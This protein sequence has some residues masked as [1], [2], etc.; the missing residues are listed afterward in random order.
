VTDSGA[1]H[2]TAARNELTETEGNTFLTSPKIISSQ[3]VGPPPGRCQ[4]L[5]AVGANKSR[6]KE[7][8]ETGEGGIEAVKMGEG[9]EGGAVKTGID[10]GDRQYQDRTISKVELITITEDRTR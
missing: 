8:V 2:T 3:V 10:G 1:V 5:G 9:L 4:L 6:R 7:A